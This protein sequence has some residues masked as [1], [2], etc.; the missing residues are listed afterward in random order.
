MKLECKAPIHVLKEL[1]N[2]QKLGVLATTVADTPH[3]SIVAFVCSA[4]QRF[5]YFGTPIATLKFR[6][7]EQ[8]A[9]VELLIDNRQ[10]LASDFSQAA[11]V[12]CIG[13]AKILK[14]NEREEAFSL[15]SARHPELSH[16]FTAP[17]CALIKINMVKYS[18]V[19]R[20]QEVI[21][22]NMTTA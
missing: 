1:L 17:T 12:S 14:E 21:E 10:N 6:N 7:I 2:Q 22:F 11:A 15:L 4:D 18:L 16:F 5:I 8:N 19:V 13:Q 3:T 9:Q 20:F